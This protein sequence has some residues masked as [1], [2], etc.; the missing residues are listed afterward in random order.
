[1][2][3]FVCFLFFILRLYPQ[4]MEVPGPEIKSEPVNYATAVAPQDPLTHCTWLGIEPTTQQQM[5]PLQ[6][7]SKPTVP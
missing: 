4:H 2:G 7:D 5:E 1:M 6:S 3:F